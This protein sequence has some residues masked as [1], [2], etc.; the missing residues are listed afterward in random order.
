VKIEIIE[1]F[2]FALRISIHTAPALKL[3]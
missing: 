2:S 3:I 1:S